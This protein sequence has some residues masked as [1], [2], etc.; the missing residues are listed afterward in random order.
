V[1]LSHR[2]S[3]VIYQPLH[4]P[5][6]VTAYSHSRPLMTAAGSWC[7]K[8]CPRQIIT[9]IPIHYLYTFYLVCALLSHTV[10]LKSK[11]KVPVIDRECCTSHSNPGRSPWH[12]ILFRALYQYRYSLP[13]QVLLFVL[14]LKLL[15][16]Q[17][18]LTRQPYSD[19]WGG[20]KWTHLPWF[21]LM[22]TPSLYWLTIGE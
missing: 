3:H 15:S 16:M 1:C 18:Y 4:L 2:H 11:S 5:R 14:I 7:Q 20:Y 13:V 9:F 10:H 21:I 22:S 17:Y 6:G 12:S 19:I 8:A